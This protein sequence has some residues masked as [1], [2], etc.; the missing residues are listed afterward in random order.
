MP[1]KLTIYKE[2]VL[3]EYWATK[4]EFEEMG[5]EV[6]LEMLSDADPLSIIEECGGFRSIFRRI[7]WVD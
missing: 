5:K 3:D 2:I 6:F 4:E 7:E 1:L